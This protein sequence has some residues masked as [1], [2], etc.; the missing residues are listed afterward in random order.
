MATRLCLPVDN[1][2]P[3]SSILGH[4]PPVHVLQLRLSHVSLDA[5]A[6]SH[7]WSSS[8]SPIL[9]TLFTPVIR[10]TQLFSHTRSLC[11]CFL[12]TG[13]VSRPYNGDSIQHCRG[14]ICAQYLSFQWDTCGDAGPGWRCWSQLDTEAPKLM[15]DRREDSGRV[16]DRIDHSDMEDERGCTRV[17]DGRIR[18]KIECEIG[19]EQQGFREGRGTTDGLFTLR[20]FVDTISGR[21]KEI[22]SLVR[23]TSVTSN[24]LVRHSHH[25]SNK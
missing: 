14:H 13:N 16:A 8:L 5:I 18:K 10:L 6:P 22:I 15:F 20:Q 1:P 12:D 23:R 4:H 7:T 21:N 11:W 9:S 25:L 17:L 2:P 24:L 19:E 3:L